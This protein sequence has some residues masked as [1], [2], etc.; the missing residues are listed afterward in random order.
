MRE[1]L[2]RSMNLASV[3]LLLNNTGIG[4]AVRHLAPFGFGPAALPRNGSLA[5]GGGNASPLDMA[6]AYAVFAN[7][8]YT[9]KPY[10]IDAIVGPDDE[11]LYRANPPVVCRECEPDA[12]QL[13]RQ[14]PEFDGSG[15]ESGAGSTSTEGTRLY[16]MSM[17]QM[18]EV[19]MSYRPDASA[20]PA[21]YA[22][23]N[24]APRVITEQ[25]AFWISDMMRDVIRRGKGRKALTRG[26]RDLS[27]K[28][29]TSN[30]RRDAWFGGFNADLSSVVYVGYDDFQPL[31]PREEGSATRCTSRSAVC[32][33]RSTPGSSDSSTPPAGSI[34][35]GRSTGRLPTRE[36]PGRAHGP[37]RLARR[38]PG[39]PLHEAPKA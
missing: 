30:D 27:G 1:A 23:I 3:R 6:Q 16:P 5:L 22:G 29:G 17:D 21:L 36:C 15:Q 32:A 28:T 9:V 10:V 24:L 2:V 34:G 7:G 35:S 19:A 31:G 11:V 38:P 14:S 20:A 12:E 25:N 26:R 37:G 39:S 18:T 33:T 4:N 13:A 8:G